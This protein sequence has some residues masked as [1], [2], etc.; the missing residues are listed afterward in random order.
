VLP[1]TPQTCRPATA[2]AS[3]RIL[4]GVAA[5]LCVLAAT[6]VD[7]RPKTD[8]VV[9][10]NGDRLHCRIEQ[11]T[12]GKLRIDTDGL[13]TVEIKWNRVDSLRSNYYYRIVTSNSSRYFGTPV[14]GDGLLQV[15]SLDVL[16]TVDQQSVVEIVEI[17]RGFWAKLNGSLSLGYSFTKA[18]QVEQ[19]NAAWDNVYQDERNRWTLR[20]SSNLTN[21]RDIEKISQRWTIG[22]DYH[23]LLKGKWTGGATLSWER[24]DELGIGQR[25]LFGLS[26]GVNPLWTNRSDLFISGG[27]NGNA[28][29]GTGSDEITE[30]WEA[31]F[32]F[33]YRF[34][35]YDSPKTNLYTSFD[36][37]P[38]LTEDKRYRTEFEIELSKE[39]ISDFFVDVSYYNSL[40]SDAPG[41]AGRRTDYGV[42]TSI[43]WSYNR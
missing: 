6:W 19:F 12:S 26:S 22:N 3:A 27:V 7:A 35:V 34:F 36:V 24:N 33:E 11:L 21:N 15:R 38:S 2:L 31:V 5:L 23:R 20:A 29:R 1:W 40:D 8:V 4:A 42:T 30:S 43:S 10:N 32:S 9:L 37:S 16:M 25:V 18:S 41:E 39:L 14:M 17:E 13:G 28:E